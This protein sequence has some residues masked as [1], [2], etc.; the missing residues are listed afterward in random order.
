MP[1]YDASNRMI[2]L[3]EREAIVLMIAGGTAIALMIAGFG[4]VNGIVTS[5][6]ISYISS[7]SPLVAGLSPLIIGGI[8]G[9]GLV[10]AL[11][12]TVGL[13]GILIMS[14]QEFPKT[15]AIATAY[16]GAAFGIGAGLVALGVTS[17]ATIG[18][19]ASL[20]LTF[21]KYLTEPPSSLMKDIY[22][23]EVQ[24]FIADKV[25]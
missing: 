19:L 12:T 3:S 2:K 8:I 16:T 7:L 15:L 11:L 20:A 21:L 25:F 4:A 9:V 6:A 13:V 10:S 23:R 24:K 17:P 5:Y 22:A 14:P 1:S 18:A